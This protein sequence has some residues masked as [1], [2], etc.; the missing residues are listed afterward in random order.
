MGYFG[1]FILGYGILPTHLT[2]PHFYTRL[3]VILYIKGLMKLEHFTI[4]L[5]GQLK[6]SLTAKTDKISP[7]VSF[8]D[9]L[10]TTIC[11]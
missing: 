7:P 6:K 1:R 2:K 3:H 10:Y 9:T 4:A 5:N 8:T 11:G